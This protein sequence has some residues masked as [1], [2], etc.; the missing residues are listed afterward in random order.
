M[1]RREIVV[2]TDDVTG[3]E[4]EDVM[5]VL[6]VANGVAYECD[7]SAPTREAYAAAI[8][9]YLSVARRIGRTTGNNVIR[10][11]FGKPK[12]P[13]RTTVDREQTKAVREWWSRN[14]GRGDLPAL[15]ERGRIPGEVMALFQTYGGQAI[16]E[17]EPAPVEPAKTRRKS[18]TVGAEF[19][20]AEPQTEE[21]PVK[22]ARQPRKAVTVKAE[23]TGAA[24]RT[25]GRAAG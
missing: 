21:A 2:Y 6:I 9:P 4:A 20:V 18:G 3:E 10:G 22:P 19:K 8:Q 23:S 5:T 17:P 14:Q 7:M 16:P 13:E 15:V 25:R 11:D 12:D 1:G 24:K